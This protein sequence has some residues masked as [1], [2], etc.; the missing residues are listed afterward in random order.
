MSKTVEIPY[1]IG[2]TEYYQKSV[3]ADFLLDVDES[4][5]RQCKLHNDINLILRQKTLH[6]QIGLDALRTYV[7]GL[8]RQQAE[9]H[10]FTDEELFSLIEPKFINNMT[11][12]YEYAKYLQEN[13]KDVESRYKSI[14]GYKQRREEFINSSKL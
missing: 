6:R 1:G 3:V 5:E 9:Q 14:K 13:S 12:A 7:Q 2:H 4:E 11:T 8:E 10:D